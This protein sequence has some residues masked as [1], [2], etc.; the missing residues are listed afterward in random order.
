MNGVTAYGPFI[1]PSLSY[2]MTNLLRTDYEYQF[3]RLVRTSDAGE[4]PLSD[5]AVVVD[6]W[7]IGSRGAGDHPCNGE[8]PGYKSCADE[9]RPESANGM[10]EARP[11]VPGFYARAGVV[12][13]R[14]PVRGL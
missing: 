10:I 6:L 3:L 14:A 4:L 1:S 7:L 11:C 9:P 2:P 5:G 8:F 13:R 12:T